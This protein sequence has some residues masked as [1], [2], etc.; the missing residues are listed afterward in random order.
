MV[1]LDTHVH[2]KIHKDWQ[3]GRTVFEQSLHFQ[4]TALR[5]I[6]YYFL[7]SPICQGWGR[8]TDKAGRPSIDNTQSAKVMTALNIAHDQAI[9]V[10]LVL[11]KESGRTC[12]EL[13]SEST[14]AVFVA[15]NIS[16]DDISP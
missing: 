14:A 6:S 15:L 3:T 10:A 5:V 12:T 8:L 11:D 9:T 4:T 1:L 13:A 2:P 7:T 16:L